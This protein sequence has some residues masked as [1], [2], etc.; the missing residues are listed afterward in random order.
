[1]ARGF[2]SGAAIGAGLA[3]PVLP[4]RALPWGLIRQM[5][6]K[7]RGGECHRI[8]LQV[9]KGHLVMREIGSISKK[10]RQDIVRVDDGTE[11]EID[12]DI[13]RDISILG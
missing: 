3:P 4:L 2:E 13:H 1:M 7:G 9:W 12:I 5:T 11:I 8:Q 10:T 6:A